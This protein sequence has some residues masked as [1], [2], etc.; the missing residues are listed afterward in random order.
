MTLF[1]I[2]HILLGANGD[3]MALNPEAD[4]KIRPRP[5]IPLV[6]CCALRLK[7]SLLSKGDS[8]GSLTLLAGS[9]CFTEAV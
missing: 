4:V 3:A 5:R 2:K 9:T 6:Q 1:L 8:Q 7:V